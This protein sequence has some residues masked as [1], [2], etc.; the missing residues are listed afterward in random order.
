MEFG[1]S[2]ACLYPMETE[3][4]LKQMLE[5]G[6][7]LFEVFL[8]AWEELSPAYL[9]ELKKMAEEYGARF[10]SVHPF[11]SPMESM[12]L[13]GNYPRRTKEGMEFYKKYMEAA[14]YL[15]GKYV[16]IHGQK[17]GTGKM[18]NP[19]YWERFGEVYRLAKTF[20]VEAAQE[21]VNLHR[22]SAPGFIKEMRQYLKDDC[23][24]VLDTKQ[25]RRAGCSV[26]EMACAMGE[27]LCHVHL[28]DYTDRRDCL[29]PGQ[30]NFD[31]PGFFSLLETLSYKGNVVVE[32]YRDSFSAEE[33]LRDALSY[34]R[35]L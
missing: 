2:T 4:S 21:N 26:E 17:P 1:I 23:A 5:G 3:K 22:S 34:L 18:E 6:Y 31:I 29:L 12:L 10:L 19:G 15:G 11:T 33:E 28:S 14:A 9:H 35:Q 24:F 27:K 25:C 16:V 8:N 30:G 20:G 32:V 13:F 7:R